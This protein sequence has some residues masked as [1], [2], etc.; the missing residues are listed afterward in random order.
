MLRTSESYPCYLVSVSMSWKHQKES[1]DMKTPTSACVP[2]PSSSLYTFPLIGYQ[3]MKHPTCLRRNIEMGFSVARSVL[4]CV[5]Q[6]YEIHGG[7]K[8]IQSAASE[9]ENHKPHA[10][11]T[12]IKL[13]SSSS[14][15]ASPLLHL[16]ILFCL[17]FGC[18]IQRTSIL[19]KAQNLLFCT[20]TPTSTLLS[21]PQ[22]PHLSDKWGTW[23]KHFY[24]LFSIPPFYVFLPRSPW[25]Y[26]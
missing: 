6:D 3:E 7:C 9:T 25:R 2:L 19:N 23:R 26:G 4:K 21:R 12:Q 1:L 8:T 10:S 24:V 16:F 13:F 18:L 15:L 17:F 22:F 5:V 20:L 14:F 11:F